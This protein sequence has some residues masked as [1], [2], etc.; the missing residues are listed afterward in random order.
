MLLAKE[1]GHELLCTPTGGTAATAAVTRRTINIMPS[2]ALR[3]SLTS[4]ANRQE[5]RGEPKLNLPPP[6]GVQNGV[7][8]ACKQG[9]LSVYLEVGRNVKCQ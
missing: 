8:M 2:S 3:L 7:V 9:V 5:A 6:K 4:R 1:K